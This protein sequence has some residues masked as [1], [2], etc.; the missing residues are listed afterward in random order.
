MLITKFI[1][2]ILCQ[3]IQKNIME[4][5]IVKIKAVVVV[6]LILKNTKNNI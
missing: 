2:K 5:M 3:K 1:K 4:K 6:F